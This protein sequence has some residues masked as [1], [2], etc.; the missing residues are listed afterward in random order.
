MLK[1][2]RSRG[3]HDT[4]STTR[5]IIENCAKRLPNKDGLEPLELFAKNIIPEIEDN[6]SIIIHKINNCDK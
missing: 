3:Y 2:K 6:M 5:E 4:F 1:N